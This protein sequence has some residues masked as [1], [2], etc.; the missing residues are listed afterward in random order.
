MVADEAYLQAGYDAVTATYGDRLGYL[1]DGL[2]LDD[3]AAG[4]APGQNAVRDRASA[5]P[6]RGA[7]SAWSWP[8]RPPY[9]WRWRRSTDRTAT[10]STSS[11]PASGWRGATPTSRRS[12]RCSRGWPTEVAPHHLV[13][14]RLPPRAGG[15]RHRAARGAV[16]AAARCGARRPGP[17]RRRGGRVRGGHDARPPAVDRHLRHPGLDGGPGPGHPGRARPP[18]R[19]CGWRPA[20]SPVSASTTS[21]RVAF[22]LGA[23]LVALRARSGAAARAAHPLAVAG[24]P[25]RRADV[26]PEPALAGR[27]RLAGLRPLRRHRRRVRRPRSAGSS[28]SARRRSCS[29]R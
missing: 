29:A 14:L 18:P 2:G 26:G 15:R 9:C 17:D 27:P 1:R 21:T 10:S 6:S 25:H 16:R 28:S 22:L 11:R 4:P 3:R 23:I 20:W 8:S 7:R 12:R 24:R 19:G 13:V 5:G